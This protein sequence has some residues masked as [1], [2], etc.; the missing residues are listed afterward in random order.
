[1]TVKSEARSLTPRQQKGRAVNAV[2]E[3]LRNRLSVPNIYLEPHIPSLAVDVL[4]VDRAGSGDLHA[5][6]VKLRVGDNFRRPGNLNQ[7][8]GAWMAYIRDAMKKTRGHLMSLPAHYRYLAIPHDSLSLLVGEIGP[9]LY[10]SD[11]IGRIG[12]IAITDRGEEPPTAE[13]AIPPERFR[14][15][16]SKLSKIEKTLINNKKVR[17]DI[18]VRI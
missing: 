14:V 11:G 15:D 3:L 4:A 18:E 17:P 1:M 10:S 16:A 13:I 5:V 12:I 2:A 7:M 9:R 6:E 8:M